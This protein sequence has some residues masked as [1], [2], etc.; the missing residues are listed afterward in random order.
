MSTPSRV[1]LNR[2][3][4]A[5]ACRDPEAVAIRC[6]GGAM[7]YGQLAQRTNGLAH[8]L[9][10]TGLQ[11]GERVAVFLG[12]GFRVPVGLYGVFAAGGLLVPIDPRS[13]SEQ[14]IRILRATGA[15]RLVTEPG[16]LEVVQAALAACPE[17]SHVVGLDTDEGV[18]AECFPWTSVSSTV[19]DRPPDVGVAES[20]PAYILHTSGSTGVPKLILHTHGSAISFLEWAVAEY[21]LTPED[22]LSNHSSH[23]TCFATFDYY[24]ASRAG[25][26]TVILTPAS[27]V[28]PGSLSA[29]L[30]QESVSVWYSVPT[31]LVHLSLR[32]S[33]EERDLSAL[34]W[35]LF[36]GESFPERHL[37]R[38]RQ[39]L[40][41]ARFSYAY[42]S[43]ETNVCAYYHLPDE[44]E[45]PNPVPIGKACPNS[46]L[47][48]ADDNLRS[49]PPGEIGELLVRGS[50]VMSG[51][52]N[53]SE[54]NQRVF[55]QPP[56][57]AEPEDPY[58]RTG[59]LVRARDDGNVTFVARADLQVKVRGH[60]V[61][62]E[63]IERSLLSLEPIEE[64][65]AYVVPDREGSSSIRAAVVAGNGAVPDRWQILDSLRQIL[66]PHAVPEKIEIRADLPLTP[67]G[68]VDRIALQTVAA[69]EVGRDGE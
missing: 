35:V 3:I 7:S 30:E 44:G 46:E 26:A 11:R 15:T 16:K 40:P 59:D 8:L 51:Y 47:R 18:Q 4:D 37:L 14:V 63:E 68:K 50:T 61:E 39:Q 60:R 17:V 13:P 58:F 56:S 33:L 62:L 1:L 12:K 43:T 29:L 34:R 45:I 55:V 6:D 54:I 9:L 5:A 36:A 41:G 28:M 53:D 65:A 22:R 48:I 23:H 19:G 52:W 64:A 20:D 57:S 21:S 42:G 49:V 38:L 66:P 2:V 32:G 10:E 24:A 31:A 69:K 25:A 27:M 67:T